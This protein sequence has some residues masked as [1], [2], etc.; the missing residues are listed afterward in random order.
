M[1]IFS[2]TGSTIKQEIVFEFFSKIRSKASGLLYGTTKTLPATKF[3]SATGV[4]SS[5][6]PAFSK[7]GLLETTNGS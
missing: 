1:P 6:S 7:D 5:A 3:E 4:G 2:R